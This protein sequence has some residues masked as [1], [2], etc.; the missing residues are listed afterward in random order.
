MHAE[1]DSS[2]SSQDLT[3][4]DPIVGIDL[5]TTNSLVAYCDDRGPRVL[6]D[7]D[8]GR[9]L[10]SVVRFQDEDVIVGRKALDEAVL[11]PKTT[12]GSSKRLLGRSARELDE[13]A[14][15]LPFEVVEGP[16][17]L[18]AIAIG[19]RR[20]TPQEVGAHVL[21]RLRQV[22]ESA[23]GT[24]VSRAVITVPAYFDDSQRNA[25]IGNGSA[26]SRSVGRRDR[27]LNPDLGPALRLLVL[28]VSID[29]LQFEEKI[30]I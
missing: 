19:T 1:D 24:S 22:A 30:S 2:Q 11:Y 7:A 12:V 27:R 13:H 23:L 26:R 21:M 9:L 20:V 28:A 29:R 3:P 4:N 8:G 25:A 6:E 14:R 17:G 5:G 10:P 15:K 18:A 16:R